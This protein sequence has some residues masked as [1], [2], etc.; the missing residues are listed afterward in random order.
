MRTHSKRRDLLFSLVRYPPLDHGCRE[1]VALEQEF[2]IVLKCRKR[3]V[4]TPRQR[5]NVRELLGRQVVNVLIERA[6]K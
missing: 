2:M 6:V 5:G 4:E 3:F 1:N